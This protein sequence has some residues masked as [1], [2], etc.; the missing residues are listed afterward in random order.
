MGG[1]RR[2][3]LATERN[4]WPPLGKKREGKMQRWMSTEVADAALIRLSWVCLCRV[5]LAAEVLRKRP[6]PQLALV[7]V[8]LHPHGRR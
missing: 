2:L 1:K 8:Y 6:G 4:M 7:M 5:P 3:Q